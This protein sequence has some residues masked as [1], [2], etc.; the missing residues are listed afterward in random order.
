M[1]KLKKFI[2]NEIKPTLEME[3]GFIELVDVKEGI[4][5]V[6]LGGACAGCPMSQF[7]LKNFVETLIKENFPDIKEVVTLA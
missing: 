6:R 4:V 2:D 1:E 5:L 7:T 3:G